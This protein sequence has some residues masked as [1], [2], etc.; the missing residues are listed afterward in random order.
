[1]QRS[2]PAVDASQKSASKGNGDT[3]RRE[4][5]GTKSNGAARP[6]SQSHRKSQPEA[7]EGMVVPSR[8]SR[9]AIRDVV[10]SDEDA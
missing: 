9:E 1:M 2:E 4:S 3:A 10:R 8:P 7:K 5:R 6:K